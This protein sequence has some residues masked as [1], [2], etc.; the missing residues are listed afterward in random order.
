ML[1]AAQAE[2]GG[3]VMSPEE[4]LLALDMLISIALVARDPV[5]CGN[6]GDWARQITELDPGGALTTSTRGVVLVELGDFAAGKALLDTVAKPDFTPSDPFETGDHILVQ[7]FIARAEGALGDPRTGRGRLG[8]VRRAI[9]TNSA[10]E[11]LRPLVDRIDRELIAGRYRS[12]TTA[13]VEALN[14]S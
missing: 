12:P 7:A 5:F 1:E 3:A 11:S 13:A 8:E 10:Y 14:G 2:L 4:R 6:L 9:G